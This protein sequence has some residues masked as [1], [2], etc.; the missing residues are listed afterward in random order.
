MH[1]GRLETSRT[2]NFHI[3]KIQN[4]G[5]RHLEKSKNGHISVTVWPVVANFGMVTHLGL[6]DPFRT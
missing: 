4:G 5:G 3:F 2:Y 1:F 6:L